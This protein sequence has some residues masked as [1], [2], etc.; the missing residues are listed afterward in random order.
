MIGISVWLTIVYSG[1]YNIAATDTHA[2]VVRGTFDTTTHR[3]V[4]NRAGKVELPERFSQEL[5]AEGAR[6]YAESCA[7]SHGAPRR[8]PATWSRGMRPEPP[9]LVKAATEWTP[10]EIHWIFQN[11]IK[12]PGMPASGP[13]HE[14]EEITAITA[15]VSQR[16]GLSPQDYQA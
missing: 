9:H 1:A 14:A 12:M 4:A 5:I 11:G 7:H 3:S 13:H 15:F 16:P 8:E 6:H 2:D 10:K